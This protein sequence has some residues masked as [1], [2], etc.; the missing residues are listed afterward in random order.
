MA[1][2]T[3]C[4]CQGYYF[5]KVRPPRLGPQTCSCGR[6]AARSQNVGTPPGAALLR[7]LRLQKLETP[8]PSAPTDGAVCTAAGTGLRSGCAGSARHSRRSTEA[9][10]RRKCLFLF[11]PE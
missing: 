11:P 9:L 3:I 6:P 8:F 5:L 4:L 7:D 2:S 1:D 10:M